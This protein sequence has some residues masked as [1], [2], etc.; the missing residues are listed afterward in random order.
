MVA[1]WSEE[2]KGRKSEDGVLGVEIAKGADQSQRLGP[3]LCS[4]LMQSSATH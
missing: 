1:V 3:A 4:N 2:E